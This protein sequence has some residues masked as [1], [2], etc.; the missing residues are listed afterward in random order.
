MSSKA[1]SQPFQLLPIFRPRVWGRR[2]LVPLFPIDSVAS[3]PIG[4]VWFTASENNTSLGPTLGELINSHPQILGTGIHPDDPTLCPLLI[5]FLFTSSR[6]SVQV[7]PDDAYAREH[8][9]SLGKSEAWHVLSA[10]PDAEVAVGFRDQIDAE[11]LRS[12]SLS[13]EIEQMLDWRKVRAG[14]TIYTPAGTVHAI[15]AGLTI[16]EIQQNSDVTYRLYDY[17]RP[18]ELHLE[19]GC[20]VSHLGPHTHKTKPVQL[21]RWREQ[22]LDSEYFRIE[23]LAA[24]DSLCFDQPSPYFQLFIA[25][26]GSGT[27]GNHPFTAG[28]VWLV[29]AGCEPFAIDGSGSEW[30]LT[31]S[32]DAPSQLQADLHKQEATPFTIEEGP[33][34]SYRPPTSSPESFGISRIRIP[35]GLSN[36]SRLNGK[37]S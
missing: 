26:K 15:G 12:A 2:S 29:P 33:R 28:Q 1:L 10:E 4:E 30:L 22:L 16:C 35:L 19:H 5:K 3:D 11:Q 7:H 27:I 37:S 17:G 8:H 31:Y 13:G 24:T 23:K 6:L 34:F 14:D 20:K 9:Q 18:R 21:E 36:N 32:A 25:L